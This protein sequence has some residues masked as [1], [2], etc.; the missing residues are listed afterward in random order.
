MG[1]KP[2]LETIEVSL[3]EA[4]IMCEPHRQSPETH[5]RRDYVFSRK[6]RNLSSPLA[7]GAKVTLTVELPP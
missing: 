1:T 6:K 4:S 2:S 7:L 3:A 5:E